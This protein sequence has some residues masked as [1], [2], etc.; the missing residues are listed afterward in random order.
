MTTQHNE[1]LNLMIVVLEETEGMGT[2]ETQR[3]ATA[4]HTQ[5]RRG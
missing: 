2:R 3:E 4:F 1:T 5:K